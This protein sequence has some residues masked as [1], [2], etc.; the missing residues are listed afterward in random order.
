[1]V[2]CKQC[3]TLNSL[4]STFCKKCGGS[5][6]QEDIAEATEKL[7]A[8]IADGN[9]LFADG[10]TD[11]AMMVAETAVNNNPSSAAAVSLK[12]MCHERKGQIA[13]ALECFER[14]VALNPDSMLDKIKVNDLR[15]LMVADKLEVPR[16]DRRVPIVAAVAASVLV[17]AG[18]AIAAKAMSKPQAPQLVASSSG[19]ANEAMRY[20]DIL[21]ATQNQPQ[22]PQNQVPSQPNNVQQDPTVPPA[23][24]NQNSPGN[25]TPRR[26]INLPEW[27]RN[28]NRLPGPNE[29]AVYGGNTPIILK[30]EG[31]IG[32]PATNPNPPKE[33]TTEP[34]GGNDPAPTPLGNGKS[35]DPVKSAS[36]PKDDPGIIEISV[37]RGGSKPS[38]NSGSVSPNGREALMQAARSQYQTKNYAAAASTYERALREGGDPAT[39]NQSLGRCYE[40]LGRNSDAIMAYQRAANAIEQALAAGGDKASLQSKLDSCR[41]AIKVLGG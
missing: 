9:K 3:N 35:G 20:G 10:R 21:G 26:D 4:D 16:T 11:E 38:R 23:I 2:S 19:S 33:N 32:G 14:V 8:M 6:A 12:R 15:N 18:G 24:T 5:L 17:I 28:D 30:P 7:T 37:A 22:T 40:N 36:E 25:T 27:G 41:Q 39:I 1:M 13:E 34:D 29:G 31:N